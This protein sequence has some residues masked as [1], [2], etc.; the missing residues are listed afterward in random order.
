MFE[1]NRGF[2]TGCTIAAHS[3]QYPV[4]VDIDQLQPA[5]ILFEI[6]VDFALDTFLDQFDFLKIRQRRRLQRQSKQGK[7]LISL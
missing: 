5:G 7:V 2:D 1:R 6:R 3:Y 4:A